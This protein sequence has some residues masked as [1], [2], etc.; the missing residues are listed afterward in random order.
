MPR[1]SK[2][3]KEALAEGRR[4]AAAVRRYLELLEEHRPRRGRKRTKASVERQLERAREQESTSDNPLTRVQAI[5][6]RMDLERELER[7]DASSEDRLEAAQKDFIQHAKEYAESKRISY[8]AFR[9]AG[10]PAEVLRKAGI[11]RGF[12][13]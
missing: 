2:E 13:P 8:T 9:E 1:M 11:N 6:E 5:Q 7:L 10:V 3:H 4:R 12:N